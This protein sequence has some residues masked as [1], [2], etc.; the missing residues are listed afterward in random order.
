MKTDRLLAILV[1]LLG[2][3]GAS[4]PQLAARFEVSKRTI[5]RDIE[6]LC[7]AGIPIVSAHGPEGGYSLMD[8]FVLDRRL[9]TATDY[10][11]LKAALRALSSAR[12]GDAAADTAEK[13]LQGSASGRTKLL[14]NLSVAREKERVAAWLPIIDEAIEEGVVLQIRYA[15]AG[16]RMTERLVEPLLL[17]YEWY[18]WYVLAYCRLRESFR[19]FK[20]DRIL[21]CAPTGMLFEPDRHGDAERILEAQHASDSRGLIFIRLRCRAEAR[22]AVTEYLSGSVERTLEDGDFIYVMHLPQEERLW[23]SL[24]LGFGDDVEV[25][26]PLSLRERLRAHAETIAEKYRTKAT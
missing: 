9:L 3:D 14:M 11:Q 10:Q 2:H 5:Q 22:I 20:L 16:Q 24:L 8:G 7:Q 19:L 1:Y 15:D 4:A 12:G 21:T 23:F 17:V 18:A 26:E 13:V 6:A 25:L